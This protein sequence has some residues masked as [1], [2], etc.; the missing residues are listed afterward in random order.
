MLTKIRVGQHLGRFFKHCKISQILGL[1]FYFKLCLNFGGLG[2]TLGDFVSQAHP[3]T[4]VGCLVTFNIDSCVS[5]PKQKRC[6]LKSGVLLRI[7]ET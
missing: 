1:P 2:N 6:H 5:L 3:V 7:G 4:L